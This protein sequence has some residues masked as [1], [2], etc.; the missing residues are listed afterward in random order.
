MRSTPF[1]PAAL[2]AVEA[3]MGG[4]AALDSTGA[5]SAMPCQW[6]RQA[7]MLEG[8]PPGVR[9]A[10]VLLRGTERQFWSG[11]YGAKFA[12]PSLRFLPPPPRG[13]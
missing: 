8:Y 1:H 6:R 10:L 3:W 12:A 11:H 9:R 13:S 5:R 4:A 2:P 7:V